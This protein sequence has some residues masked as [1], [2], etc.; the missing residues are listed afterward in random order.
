MAE[1]Q[2]AKEQEQ[3]EDAIV[4]SGRIGGSMTVAR[5]SDVGKC[6]LCGAAVWISPTSAEIIKLKNARVQCIACA[7]PAMQERREEIMP[8]NNGQ[9]KEIAD[10]LGLP[11]EEVLD[12]LDELYAEIQADPAGTFQKLIRKKKEKGD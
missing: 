8:L 5:G 12:W 3:E 9:I 1:E 10:N 2:V 6:E 7:M 11:L 4:V